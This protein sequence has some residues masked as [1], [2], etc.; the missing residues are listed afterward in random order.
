M[1][2]LLTIASTLVTTWLSAS[3]I[4]Q[5]DNVRLRNSIRAQTND[6]KIR[7]C[8]IRPPRDITAHLDVTLLS[9][10]KAVEE[11]VND[12]DKVARDRLDRFDPTDEKT[13]Y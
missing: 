7:L 8:L 11:M 3:M 12:G 10:G 5:I 1:H 9:F 6:P 13:W 2:Y 4:A